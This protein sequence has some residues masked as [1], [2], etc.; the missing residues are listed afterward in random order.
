MSPEVVSP[1]VV[2]PEVVS[3]EVVSYTTN[4]KTTITRMKAPFKW[5]CMT[6]KACSNY[7]MS[8]LES[9]EHDVTRLTIRGCNN[10]VT[11]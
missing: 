6:L 3:P 9:N 11:S 8:P 2:S 4:K 7:L 5:K 1:E 10:I